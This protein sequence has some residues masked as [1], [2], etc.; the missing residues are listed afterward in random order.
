MDLD[1]LKQAIVADF[2]EHMRNGDAAGQVVE[3]ACMF[4]SM[5]QVNSLFIGHGTNRPATVFPSL[6]EGSTLSEN[7]HRILGSCQAFEFAKHNGKS[8]AHATH[9]THAMVVAAVRKLFE[10]DATWFQSYVFTFLTKPMAEHR[11]S[12]LLSGARLNHDRNKIMALRATVVAIAAAQEKIDGVLKDVSSVSCIVRPPGHHAGYAAAG[13]CYINNAVFL[14]THL[15]INKHKVRFIDVDYHLGDGFLALCRDNSPWYKAFRDK[16]DCVDTCTISNTG[17]AE[18]NDHLLQ[19]SSFEYPFETPSAN[20]SELKN[21]MFYPEPTIMTKYWKHG[22]TSAL[23]ISRDAVV[24]NLLEYKAPPG[25]PTVA[26]TNM[27]YEEEGATIVFQSKNGDIVVIAHIVG[28]KPSEGAPKGPL[29]DARAIEYLT[30]A[31]AELNTRDFQPTI[32]V[33]AAGS[34]GCARDRINRGGSQFCPGEDY[35]SAE[36]VFSFVSKTARGGKPIMVT[37]EGGYEQSCNRRMHFTHLCGLCDDEPQCM[38]PSGVEI[39]H[40]VWALAED[41]GLYWY[42]GTVHADGGDSV[43]VL[44]ADGD[45]LEVDCWKVRPFKQLRVKENVE[46]LKQSARGRRFFQ[47]TIQS[48]QGTEYTVE[49]DGVAHT[50][51]LGAIRKPTE[52]VKKRETQAYDAEVQYTDEDGT[53]WF[54]AHVEGDGPGAIV[55]FADGDVEPLGPRIKRNFTDYT[56]GAAVEAKP[57]WQRRYFEGT[58]TSVNSGKRTATVR[59]NSDKEEQVSFSKLRRRT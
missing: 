33:E 26:L 48:I 50:V 49:V 36:S 19:R 46:I 5:E 17:R 57:R 53:Y 4:P 20:A 35:A 8:V 14:A 7:R 37:Q 30:I 29:T 18:T 41:D 28:E 54:A 23:P 21:Q 32:V 31:L 1:S 2:D 58:I 56:T 13:F 25:G 47:G 55:H 12:D 6:R 45:R 38:L 24:P 34:D 9:L 42:A 59:F 40:R 3:K 39:G 51:N 44:F 11:D 15:M 43:D 16:F 52:W 10:Y 22:Q 27:L